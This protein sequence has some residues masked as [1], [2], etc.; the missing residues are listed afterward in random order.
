MSFRYYNRFEIFFLRL[1]RIFYI[2]S[3]LIEIVVLEF[4][5]F[6]ILIKILDRRDSVY[7]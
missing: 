1:S 7:G 5:K 6:K 2:L 3:K 4:L